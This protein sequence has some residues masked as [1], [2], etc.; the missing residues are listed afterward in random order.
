[1]IYQAARNIFPLSLFEFRSRL[2]VQRCRRSAGRG[3]AIQWSVYLFLPPDVPRAESENFQM[4]DETIDLSKLPQIE[5]LALADGTYRPL[6]I[7][8]RVELFME[9]ESYPHTP[10]MG[11]EVPPRLAQKLGEPAYRDFEKPSGKGRGRVVRYFTRDQICKVLP[12]S[13]DDQ[14]GL[15]SPLLA[16]GPT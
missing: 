9:A 5:L 4:Q 3:S 8:D 14:Q 11:Y 16:D 12:V 10:S 7:T 13:E 6:W 1:M 15:D 2:Q